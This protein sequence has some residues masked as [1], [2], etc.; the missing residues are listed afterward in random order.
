MKISHI[1]LRSRIKDDDTSTVL[2]RS[3]DRGNPWVETDIVQGDIGASVTT[4]HSVH[5]LFREASARREFFDEAE[6]Q[7]D[8]VFETLI[9]LERRACEPVNFKLSIFDADNVEVFHTDDT[10]DSQRFST[11]IQT[12][13]STGV[14]EFGD[15]TTVN[16]NVPGLEGLGRALATGAHGRFHPLSM[17]FFGD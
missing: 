11:A 16:F 3:I 17:R 6:L 12:F 13:P 15:G 4:D 2:F 1:S 5:T 14:F 9:Y 10:L 7:E 8:Q